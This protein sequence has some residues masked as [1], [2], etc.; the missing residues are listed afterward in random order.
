MKAEILLNT[1]TPAGTI[2]LKL[3]GNQQSAFGAMVALA[4]S[5]MLIP[6]I[7]TIQLFVNYDEDDMEINQMELR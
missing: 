2:K 3:T 4:S 5:A 6:P 7:S 1:P